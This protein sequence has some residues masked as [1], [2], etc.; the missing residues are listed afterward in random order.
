MRDSND[1]IT[2]YY[3]NMVL[4]SATKPCKTLVGNHRRGEKMK[5]LLT[6]ICI[7]FTLSGY[8]YGTSVVG[9]FDGDGVSDAA[10]YH[11]ATGNWFI[12]LCT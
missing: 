7:L 2:C 1:T 8:A 6:T 5:T 10:V 4:Q 3:A 9:D 11:D 12:G